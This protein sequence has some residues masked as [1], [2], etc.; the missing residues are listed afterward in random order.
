MGGDGKEFSFPH[1]VVVRE[2]AET[3]KMRIVYDASARAN[4]SAAPLNECLEVGPP[5][6][7]QLLSVMFRNR[8]YPVAIAGDLR[9]A[10]LQ[11]RVRGADRDALRFHWLTNLRSKQVE[12]LRFTRVLFGLAPSP[13]LL[14]TVIRGHFRRYKSVIPKLVEEIERSMYVNDLITGGE[15]LKQALET[16]QTPRVIFSEA[17]FEPHKGQSNV[18]DLEADNSSP[19]EESQTYAKQ[20]LG[21]KANLNCWEF[22][23]IKRETKSKSSF[24]RSPLNRPRGVSWQR[25]LK[26]MIRSD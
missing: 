14:A 24:R 11:I 25:S 21:A 16:K 19:D 26:S 7:N 2:N 18:R 13:F 22:P 10:F 3:T 12:T 1:K 9:Q 23:G 8:L 17:T 6:Q 4:S 15:S 5:L 20:Q